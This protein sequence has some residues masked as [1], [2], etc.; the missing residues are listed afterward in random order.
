MKGGVGLGRE[1]YGR[2]RLSNDPRRA[3]IREGGFRAGVLC[4]RFAFRPCERR[5]PFSPR[6]NPSQMDALRNAQTARRQASP[7]FMSVSMAAF[8][9]ASLS[10]SR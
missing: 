6:L 5:S 9:S 8:A 4:E 3:M 7:S 2:A 1:N 10:K